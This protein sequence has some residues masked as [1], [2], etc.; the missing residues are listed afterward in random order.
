MRKLSIL[1]SILFT[2][3][4]LSSC[5]N[6]DDTRQGDKYFAEGKY[7]EAIASY[8]KYLGLHPHDSKTL[9]NKGRALEELG[10]RE[11]ALK[12]FQEILK[13]DPKYTAAELSVGKYYFQ[14]KDFDKASFHFEKATKLAPQNAQAFFLWGRALHEQGMFKEAVEKY[15]AAIRQ[16]NTFGEP[17]LYRGAIR[18]RQKHQAQGC[19]D[20][21]TAL[22]LGVDQAKQAIAKYCH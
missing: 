22:S 15:N 17:Y 11:E 16:D 6:Q 5:S 8:N 14:K 21:R 10:K 13:Q 18:V 7:K 1:F 2:V 3:A 4:L 20:F 9:Y 12:I 19:Q